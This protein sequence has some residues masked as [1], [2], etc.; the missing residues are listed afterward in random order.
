MIDADGNPSDIGALPPYCES[1]Y[2]CAGVCGGTS[3]VDACGIC[4]GSGIADGTCDCDG[5][6]EDC[7]GV[8]GGTSV[9]DECG[10]CDGSG[11]ADGT[12]DCAGN[13]VDC[14]GVCGGTS[15]EDACG[16]CGG[17][18]I[19]DGTCDCAGN[20][21]DCAG[22]CGGSAENCPTWEDCQSCY[23]NTASMTAVVLNALTGSQMGDSG[24]ILA[25]F[26]SD[27]N[28]R[29]IALQLD[30]I[31]PFSPYTGSIL[32]EIQIRAGTPESSGG[33]GDAISFKYYDA[34][35]DEVLDSGTGYTFI[36]DD[37]IGDVVT[38]HEI[39]V[40]AVL[41]SIDIE[42]GWNWFSLNVEG[43]MSIGSVMGSLTST[44]GDFIKSASASSTYYPDFGWYGGLDELG[45]TGMYKFNS[46]NSDLLVFSG[47]PVDPLSTPI[48]L[49]SGWNW[50]GFTPQ[51]DGA[52]ADALGSITTSE[53]DFI[54]NQGASSTYYSDFGWYGGLEELGVT[55]MY[56]FDSANEDELVFSDAVIDP[57]ASTVAPSC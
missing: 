46:A 55:G 30:D 38:P 35:E 6:V 11:I 2:D 37:Q 42:S 31:P 20:V 27:G 23:E 4:D 43:D 1:S 21:E 7:A 32:Y 40:G 3:V 57:S 53:G 13:V 12:C 44:D 24:D 22:V 9:V 36:I 33:A 49:E 28:V 8:C 26:D 48:D 17:S 29:G 41:V 25:A 45:V 50:L 51:N 39:S 56:K 54:K 16:V 52:T 10:V 19:A 18:G 15:V 5:N 47:A 34:S 14:A